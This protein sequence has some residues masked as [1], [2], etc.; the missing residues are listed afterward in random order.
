MELLRS[1]QEVDIHENAELDEQADQAKSYEQAIL[2][3]QDYEKLIAPKK[4]IQ[5]S[6]MVWWY[7]KKELN[8]SRSTVYVKLSLLKLLEKYPKL[9]KSLLTLNFLKNYFKTIQEAFKLI[10][11]TILLFEVWIRFV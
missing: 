4:P 5:R 8:I 7:F 6:I 3:V 1:L 10:L 2:L 11:W 9:N